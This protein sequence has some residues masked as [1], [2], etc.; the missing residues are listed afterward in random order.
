MV[1]RVVLESAGVFL[2]RASV[3]GLE[4]GL[5][6]KRRQTGAQICSDICY[7]GL[8]R[9]VN[10]PG[11][12]KEIRAAYGAGYRMGEMLRRNGDA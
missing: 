5:H 9:T 6:G 7:Y 8:W 10:R 2:C 1:D 3:V 4:D 11:Y 12:R